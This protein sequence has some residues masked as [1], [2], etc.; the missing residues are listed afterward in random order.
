[1]IKNLLLIACTAV[2]CSCSLEAVLPPLWQGVAELK[3]ILEDRYLGHYLS[4]GDYIVDIK[5]VDDGYIIISAKDQ[6]HAQVIYDQPPAGFVGPAKFHIQF[7]PS[8]SVTN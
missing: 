2:A 5:K 6:I 7:S 8:N 1:M 3:A 4:S